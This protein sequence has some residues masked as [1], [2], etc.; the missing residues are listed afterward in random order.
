MNDDGPAAR[1][2]NPPACS[3]RRAFILVAS[4]GRPL[5]TLRPPSWR[6]FSAPPALRSD[7]HF[8]STRPPR[9]SKRRPPHGGVTQSRPPSASVFQSAEDFSASRRR[10]VAAVRQT[11]G[12]KHLAVCILCVNNTPTRPKTMSFKSLSRRNPQ[13]K[14]H[15]IR[16][17]QMTK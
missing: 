16:T 12:Q 9:C 1:P 17:K 11:A 6:P 2:T 10:E 3:N 13:S 7:H 15:A 5:R 8:R 14:S 4:H